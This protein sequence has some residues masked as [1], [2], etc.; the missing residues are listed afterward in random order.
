M[1]ITHKRYDTFDDLYVFAYRVAGVVGLMMTYVLGAKSEEAFIYAEKL[2][3]AMQLTNILRDIQ[4]DKNM[5]RIY[6]PKED[7]AS[8]GL[9]EDDIFNEKMQPKMRRL[10]KFQIRRAHSY[11][12][13]GNKGIHLLARDAQFAIY[14]SS[15]IYRGILRKIEARNYNPFLGRVYV[16]QLKKVGILLQEVIRTRVLMPNYIPAPV[17]LE[18]NF[19]DEK[20]A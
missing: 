17:K 13:Q 8:F 20:R 14:S 9:T 16:P 4:E 7:L 10:M 12:N 18:Y 1:D 6:L 5:G 2:G 19:I 3:I 15:K 11:Y